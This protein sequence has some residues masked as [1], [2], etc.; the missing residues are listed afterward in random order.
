M[1]YT[2]EDS[3][4]QF[5]KNISISCDLSDAVETRTNLAID[6]LSKKFDILEI[7]PTGSLLTYTT[8]KKYTTIDIV[9]VLHYSKYIKNK[10][11]IDLF[12][13]VKKTLSAYNT[14][15]TKK[16]K[17]AITLIFK[18][19]PHVNIIPA[20]RVLDGDK[21]SHYNIPSIDKDIWIASN[22]KIHTQNMREFNIYKSKLVQIIKE[23]NLNNSSY[24]SS[25]HIDNI[26]LSYEE[27]VNSDFS[28]HVC[29]FFKHMY[30]KIEKK[31]PN[32]N[33]LGSFVDDYLDNYTR[34]E[35]LK[36]IDE[37]ITL[38]YDAWYEIYSDKSHKLSIET[39]CECFG[40]RFPKYGK[41]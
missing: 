34:E 21:F 28:W 31:F 13:I 38:T 33:G 22:P 24:L 39:Y 1:A 6:L 12:R 27:E 5:I 3:F 16:N 37:T 20:S 41:S 7:F 30:D 19:A 11:P 32:P 26:A 35:V 14:K 9:V 40:E 36:L 17:H 10:E 8:L 18:K 29:K 25:F 15:I 23:W 4:T 2:V